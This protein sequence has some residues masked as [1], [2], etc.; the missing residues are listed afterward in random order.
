MQCELLIKMF[1]MVSKIFDINVEN[2]VEVIDNRNQM[3]L[4]HVE[5]YIFSNP[6]CQQLVK[7]SL[8]TFRI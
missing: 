7:F 8:Q 5:E 6:C 1:M 3:S 4:R 2:T